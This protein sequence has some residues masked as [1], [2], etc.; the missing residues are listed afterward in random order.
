LFFLWPASAI[1]CHRKETAP[2]PKVTLGFCYGNLLSNVQDI[3]SGEGRKQVYTFGVSSLA[4]IDE[5]LLCEVLYEAILVDD[6]F[7]KKNK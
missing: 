3:L 5:Q 7:F 6:Q 2:P 1:P 4:T